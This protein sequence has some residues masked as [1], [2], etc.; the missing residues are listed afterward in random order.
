MAAVRGSIWPW[1]LINPHTVHTRGCADM[2]ILHYGAVAFPNQKTWWGNVFS[3]LNMS[4]C[5]I[6]TNWS[7][8]AQGFFAYTEHN[9]LTDIIVPRSNY[10]LWHSLGISLFVII[11][12]CFYIQYCKK[13]Q[14]HDVWQPCSKGQLQPKVISVELKVNFPLKTCGH[15]QILTAVIWHYKYLCYA[16]LMKY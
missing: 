13:Q 6:G 5:S 9:L 1:W 2:R 10:I 16:R 3:N 11:M 4:K 12:T 15:Q 14:K 8:S 7:T